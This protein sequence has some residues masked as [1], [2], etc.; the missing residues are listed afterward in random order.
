M[1]DRGFLPL[2][3]SLLAAAAL[4][5]GCGFHLRGEIPGTPESK[6]F[7]IS[8]LPAN[9]AFYGDFRR[10]L[11]Y[12]GGKI[13]EKPAKAAALVNFFM[14]RHERRPITLSR[15]GRANMFEL[16]FRVVYQILTPKGDVLLPQN[17][18]IIRRDYFNNQVSP[19]GQ[20]QE[21]SMMR[22]EMEKEAAL[23]LLRRVVYALKNKQPEPAAKS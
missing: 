12:S 16:T 3:V 13:T 11:G 5:A 19:L 14:A 7:F 15:Q 20:V 4:L 10:V 23:A 9:D 1:S 2:R 18:M 6:T 21:E 17:E 8:G 22:E